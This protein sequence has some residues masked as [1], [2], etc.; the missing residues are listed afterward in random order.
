M[1]MTNRTGL[2]AILC[3]LAML[4]APELAAAAAEPAAT[5]VIPP[6]APPP[7][8]I[9]KPSPAATVHKPMPAPAEKAE[10][11]SH[12][13]P[14]HATAAKK[15]NRTA[16]HTAS[17]R[18]PAAIAQRRERPH[19]TEPHATE[20]RRVVARSIP[21]P[22]APPREYTGMPMPGIDEPP[23]PLPPPWYDRARPAIAFAYPPPFMGPRGP[24]PWWPR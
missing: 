5:A 2:S 18:K 3:G 4:F 23:P 16:V 8:A 15:T 20:H 11:G 12:G 1:R 7:A 17:S 6:P 9:H 22:A 13:K 21:R 24:M 10:A 19:T 14:R